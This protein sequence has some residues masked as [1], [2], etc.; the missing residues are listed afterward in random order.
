MHSNSCLPNTY[1]ALST[2]G[3][4]D[5]AESAGVELA[6]PTSMVNS[7]QLQ[8]GVGLLRDGTAIVFMDRIACCPRP[9]IAWYMNKLVRR[10]SYMMKSKHSRLKNSQL[11]VLV[12]I[13]PHHSW[14][15]TSDMPHLLSVLVASDPD[16]GMVVGEL[17]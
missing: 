7:A 17:D 5:P 4:R 3:A 13:E 1:I 12:Q 6:H 15:S 8:I 14:A 11:A 16:V 2:P 10:V 9:E